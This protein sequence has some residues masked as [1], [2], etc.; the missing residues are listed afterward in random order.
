[1]I[2][3]AEVPQGRIYLAAIRD[4]TQH[5][6]AEAR[7]R[8][9]REA[10]TIINHVG[11]ML[12]AELNLDALLQEVTDAATNLTGATLGAFLHRT[13]GEDK[14]PFTLY[15]LSGAGATV[16]DVETIVPGTD[17]LASLFIGD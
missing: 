3:A 1:L 11:R 7:L 14:A 15:T 8:E 17:G 12:S 9:E 16:R 6:E 5:R 10:L 4:M 2:T 13:P